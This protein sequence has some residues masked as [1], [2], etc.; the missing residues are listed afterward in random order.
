MNAVFADEDKPAQKR[1]NEILQGDG[2]G[3]GGK[4]EDGWCLLGRAK[5]DEQNEHHANKLD[6]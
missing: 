4:T 2:E 6:A 1:E 5:D 3:S